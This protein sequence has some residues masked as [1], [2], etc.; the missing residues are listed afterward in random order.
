MCGCAALLM[1]GCIKDGEGNCPKGMYLTFENIMPKYQFNDVV[2]RLNLYLYDENSALVGDYVFNRDELAAADYKAYIDQ[3]PA[4]DYSLVAMVNYESD[5]NVAN[6]ND[7]RNLHASLLPGTD[8]V[9]VIPTDT[10]QAKQTLSFG[11]PQESGS[12]DTQ[13]VM[14]S[15][16]TNRVNLSIVL[17]DCQMGENQ[18]WDVNLNGNNGEFDFATYHCVPESFKVYMPVNFTRAAEDDP[19]FDY[20]F[21]TMR[22]SIGDDMNIN[23][24][25]L[26]SGVKV[27]NVATMGVTAIL[28][29]VTD[30]SGY[31]PYDTD[32]KLELEDVFNIKFVVD[33][34]YKI[35]E[36][37]VNDWYKID[38]DMDL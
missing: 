33:G 18:S 22:L 28:A 35:T 30:S 4:G 38:D 31:K 32:E 2:D 1:S 23:I 15:K 37:I 12:V 26:D 36:I 9:R 11:T 3:Q 24:D 5:Y 14:L 20:S 25:L 7:I 8:T 13:K 6:P 29:Q 10:W 16:N 19:E 27:K 34:S 17:D 21:G